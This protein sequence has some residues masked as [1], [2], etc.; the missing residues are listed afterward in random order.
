MSYTALQRLAHM[1]REIVASGLHRLEQL[2]LLSRIKR[3]IRE[4]GH[5][6][7]VRTRQA[8][9]AYILHP[10]AVH[11]EFDAATVDKQMEILYVHLRPTRL[12]EKRNG[13][14]RRCGRLPR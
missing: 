3:R 5:Q 1:A 13:H 10:P 14:W 11:S 8:T 7:G 6:G 9:S 2:G 4:A 12:R